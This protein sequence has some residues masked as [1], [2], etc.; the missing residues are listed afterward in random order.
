M[1]YWLLSALLHFPSHFVTL[2]RGMA[3]LRRFLA[4]VAVDDETMSTLYSC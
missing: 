2:Q 1:N 3:F 4:L